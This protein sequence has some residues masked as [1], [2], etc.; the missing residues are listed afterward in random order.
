MTPRRDRLGA[1]CVVAALCLSACGATAQGGDTT[2]PAPAAVI[3]VGEL[4]PPLVTTTST[5]PTVAETTPETVAVTTT[6]I[7]FSAPGNRILMIGDSILASTSKRY[8]NDMCRALVPL[9]WRVAIEAEVSRGIDFGVDVV[10]ARGDEGWDAALVFLG[11]NYGND[12]NAYLRTLNRIVTELGDIPIVLV[13]VSEYRDEVRE[14]NQVV[15]TMPEVYDNISVVDWRAITAAYPDVLN[16][17]GIH[18]TPAGREVLA[19]AVATHLG[20]APTSPGSC[21]DSQFTDDSSGT[22]DGRP[23]GSGSGSGSGNSATT[24]TVRAGSATTTTVRAGTTTTTV[25]P[26]TTTTTT[27][28]SGGSGG[29]GGSTTTAPTVA[30]TTTAPAVTVPTTPVVTAA[31]APTTTGP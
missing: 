7:P 27:T 18:P 21:L 19:E 14:V 6:T 1:L 13:T 28:P 4:P 26:A 23:T 2:S 30:T 10:R 12:E 24:T 8:S 29:S 16:E 31:P 20:A 22:I 25:R 9:G 11:T 17:D 5:V 3:G 15:T